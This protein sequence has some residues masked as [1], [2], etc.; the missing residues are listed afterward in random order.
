MAEEVPS[1]MNSIHRCMIGS[2]GFLCQIIFQLKVLPIIWNVPKTSENS[3]SLTPKKLF[4][5]IEVKKT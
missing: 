4:N 5:N 2:F 3:A 1:G